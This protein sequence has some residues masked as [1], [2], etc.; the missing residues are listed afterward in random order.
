MKQYTIPL[1]FAGLFSLMLAPPAR[2][3]ASEP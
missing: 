1:A 3:D 2:A